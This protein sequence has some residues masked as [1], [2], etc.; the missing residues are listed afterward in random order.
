VPSALKHAFQPLYQDIIR[1]RIAQNVSK[2]EAAV[3]KREQV[4]CVANRF[5]W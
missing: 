2:V 4:Q 1:T 3:K 5:D